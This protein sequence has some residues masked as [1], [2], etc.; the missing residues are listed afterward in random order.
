MRQNET[1]VIF[2]TLKTLY[3]DIRGK[4]MKCVLLQIRDQVKVPF[5][6]I[7]GCF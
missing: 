1:N 5:E 7:K 3:Q 4:S 6:F 2:I